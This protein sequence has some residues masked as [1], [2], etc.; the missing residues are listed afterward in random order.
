MEKL[1]NEYIIIFRAHYLLQIRLILQN[2]MALYD[3][4]KIDDI[5]ELYLISDL[6]ITDYSS[7]IF[8]YANLK[9]PIIFYMYDLNYYKEELRGFYLNLD[10][11]P[12][13]IVSTEEEIVNILNNIDSYAEKYNMKYLEF[14]KMFNYLDDGKSSERVINKVIK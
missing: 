8:D 11:L 5:N 9:K 12:G 2:I 4:S 3:L 14:N 13:D 6:L 1:N 7:L 10:E